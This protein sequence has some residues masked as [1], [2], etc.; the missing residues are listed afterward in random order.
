MGTVAYQLFRHILHSKKR[1]KKIKSHNKKTHTTK[2]KRLIPAWIQ[3]CS[4]P[5][6]STLP[7]QIWAHGLKWGIPTLWWIGNG[8][9]LHHSGCS[10][11]SKGCDEGQLSPEQPPFHDHAL[12]SL[13]SPAMVG[14]RRRNKEHQLILL[15]H[16]WFLCNYHLLEYSSWP[17][18]R[19]GGIEKSGWRDLKAKALLEQ[20]PVP[21]PQ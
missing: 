12:D 2:I 6:V 9:F 17:N 18:F 10:G 13:F 15:I 21:P 19:G 5:P 1:N 11:Q 20:S 4:F 14:S 16:F 8:L 7:K 3:L